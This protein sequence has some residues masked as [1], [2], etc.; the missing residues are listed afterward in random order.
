M[1]SVTSRYARAFAEVVVDRR[2][3]A[4]KS[5]EELDSIAG[6]IESN[7][8]LRNVLQNPAVPRAQ[9]LKLLDAIVGRMGASKELRNFVAVLVDHHRAR[10]MDEI[11]KQFKRELNQK[12]GIAESEVSSARE[13]SK[14]ERQ[15]LEKELQAITGKTVQA[16]YS[17]DETLL[18][19]VVVR[20]GSTIYD[21]SVRG[22]LHKIREQITGS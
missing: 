5:V 3:N 10:H 16:T 13:L 18:G 20:I 15:A 9:K 17:K 19:G 8:D 14:E 6:L 22:Q 21:G 7:T 2:M 12:L 4:E 1:A 11:A